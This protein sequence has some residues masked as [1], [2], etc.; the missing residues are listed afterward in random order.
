MSGSGRTE[1]GRG[2]LGT[3]LSGLA[4]AVGCVLFLGGFAW[5]ALVYR[6]YTVPTGSMA[7]TVETGAKVLAERISG[8]EVRRGD[9]VVFTDKAWSN[10]PMV[11]RVVGIGGDTVACCDA[12]GRLGVNG[13][14][15]EEP[16]LRTASEGAGDSGRSGDSEGST[17]SGEG[18]APGASS[19][20]FSAK[21]PDGELFLLG[22]DRAISLDSR[23]HLTDQGQG[24]VRRDAVVAR[25]DAVAWPSAGLLDPPEGFAALPGG[26]SSRGPLMLQLAALVVGV[27]L[28]LGGCAYGPVAAWTRRRGKP[29]KA[30]TGVR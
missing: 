23:V 4:V 10:V 25:V 13:E 28:I 22:D 14:P 26:I 2:R 29:A 30:A 9:V 19:T 7:P 20:E 16:Y 8:D 11:K 27:V 18:E 21:V 15:I 12:E 3:V 1:D 24:S 5:A 17:G 6:P